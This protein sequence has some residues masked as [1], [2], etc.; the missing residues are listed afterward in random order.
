MS[1]KG[2]DG[3]EYNPAGK[4]REGIEVSRHDAIDN[5]LLPISPASGA[6]RKVMLHWRKTGKVTHGQAE[7][8]TP[9]TWRARATTTETPL[10]THRSAGDGRRAY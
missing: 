4:Q 2:S 8:T 10:A 9:R 1:E 7:E 3:A 5:D 6:A